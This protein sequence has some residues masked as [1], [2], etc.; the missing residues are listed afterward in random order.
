[1]RPAARSSA[2]TPRRADDFREALGL[3]RGEALADI[4][5]EPSIQAEAA[6]LE[7]LRLAALEDRIDAELAVGAAPISSTSWNALSRQIRSGDTSGDR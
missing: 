6:R 2:A 1:M 7:D 3:W 4:G 5:F